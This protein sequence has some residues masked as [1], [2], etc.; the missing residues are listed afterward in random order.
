MRNEN[1][2]FRISQY[3][4]NNP[5]KWFN[6]KLNCVMEPCALYNE[7]VWMVLI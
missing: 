4:K 2:L 1:E 5:E 3:I 7:E 6:D